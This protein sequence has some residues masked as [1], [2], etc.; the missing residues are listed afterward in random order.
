[1]NNQ[2]PSPPWFDPSLSGPA[3]RFAEYA[4]AE[5]QRR[6]DAEP[7]FDAER[8][9]AAVETVLRRLREDDGEASR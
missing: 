6:L 1:M 5:R 2:T 8:F 7:H 9:D 3:A 4:V